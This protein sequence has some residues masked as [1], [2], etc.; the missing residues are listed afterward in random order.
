MTDVVLKA[1]VE[2]ANKIRERKRHDYCMGC[3][4]ARYEVCTPNC[5]VVI[6]LGT[7]AGIPDGSTLHFYEC[8]HTLHESSVMDGVKI[9]R[10]KHKCAKCGGNN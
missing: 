4:N 2:M 8:G 1:A 7:E 9:E 10:H 3:G 5:P 6:V